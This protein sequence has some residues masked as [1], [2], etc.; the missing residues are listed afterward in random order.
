MPGLD[1]YDADVLDDGEYDAM[2]Q[3]D[4]QAAEAAMKRRDREGGMLG[5][6]GDRELIYDDSDEE[7]EPR[8][9]RRMAEKAAAGE[10]E[11]TDMIESIENLEDTKGHSIKEWVSMLGPST[12]IANRFKNFLRNYVNSKGQY[13]YKDR[14]RR[15]CE[16]NHCSL[17]VII[18]AFSLKVASDACLEFL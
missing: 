4:R 10:M 17:E 5:R 8:R 9:K 1:R 6:R 3:S 16:N 18:F 13:V 11:D 7:D 2:S 12:E 15:M 14:I